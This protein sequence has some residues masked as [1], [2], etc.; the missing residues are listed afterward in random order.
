MLEMMFHN[1]GY[2]CRGIVGDTYI[3]NEMRLG[4][5]KL[6]PVRG[7]LRGLRTAWFRYRILTGAWQFN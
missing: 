4:K 3:V 1:G 2:I 6:E 5:S 7:R